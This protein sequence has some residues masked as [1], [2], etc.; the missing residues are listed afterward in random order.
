MKQNAGPVAIVIG[1]IAVIGL[2]VFLFV[3]AGQTDSVNNAG[4]I[5]QRPGY[6]GGGGGSA[7]QPPA[8]VSAPGMAGQGR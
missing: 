6:A 2:I 7:G 8:N 1:A 4:P 3:K 5:G